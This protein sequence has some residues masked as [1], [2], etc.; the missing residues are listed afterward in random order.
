MS[1]VVGSCVSMCV[2]TSIASEVAACELGERCDSMG[3]NRDGSGSICDSSLWGICSQDLT[4][5]V[6]SHKFLKIK[7]HEGHDHMKSYEKQSSILARD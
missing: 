7:E 4:W 5:R 3:G 2:S 1:G 6:L